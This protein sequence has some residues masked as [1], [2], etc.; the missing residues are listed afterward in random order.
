MTAPPFSELI[1]EEIYTWS[2]PT[3]NNSKFTSY[4]YVFPSQLLPERSRK[5]GNRG[6]KSPVWWLISNSQPRAFHPSTRLLTYEVCEYVKATSTKLC[7]LN[8]PYYT[9]KPRH[10]SR[11][12]WYISYLSSLGLLYVSS[13]NSILS[14]SFHLPPSKN[15]QRYGKWK[16]TLEH[17]SEI[18]IQRHFGIRQHDLVPWLSMSV[19]LCADLG[20]LW[21]SVGESFSAQSYLST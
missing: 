5:W 15:C 8:F 11:Y 6:T 17:L 19:V 14:K 7:C 16:W 2:V 1:S 21:K 13:I 20:M 18:K 10:K 9:Q 12:K 4:H 3:A